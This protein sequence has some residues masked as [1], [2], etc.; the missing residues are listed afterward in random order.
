MIMAILGAG[1]LTLPYICLENGLIFGSFLLFIG[2][3]VSNYAGMRFIE[4]TT[5]AKSMKYT[6]FALQLYGPLAAKITGWAI[7][8]CLLGFCISYIVF[9]KLLIP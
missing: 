9:L 3:L 1:T 2:A 8:L 5:R 6:D 4:C 7:V